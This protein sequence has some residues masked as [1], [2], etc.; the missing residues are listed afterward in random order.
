MLRRILRFF[1]KKEDICVGSDFKVLRIETKEKYWRMVSGFTFTPHWCIGTTH[2]CFLQFHE[3]TRFQLFME[4]SCIWFHE[5][6][7]GCLDQW[8]SNETE[9]NWHTGAQFFSCEH[10]VQRY[11]M[12]KWKK[13]IPVVMLQNRV[14]TCFWWESCGNRFKGAK[15]FYTIIAWR[16]R[17]VPI[18]FS[19]SVTSCF[20]FAWANR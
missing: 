5:E 7:S 4:D 10:Y 14:I 19:S 1:S 3:N 16:G 17:H 8:D 2:S 12:D 9:T 11:D 20:L 15:C 13:I 6:L 18:L